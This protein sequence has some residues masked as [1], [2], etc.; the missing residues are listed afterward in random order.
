[1]TKKQKAAIAVQP[2]LSQPVEIPQDLQDKIAALKA[3]ALT[4]KLL[5]SGSFPVAAHDGIKSAN[6]FLTSLH[7]QL[8]AEA[9]NHPSSSLIPELNPNKEG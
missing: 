9:Q 1:M 8:M 4:H 3:I 6:A 5:N 7:E 2:E